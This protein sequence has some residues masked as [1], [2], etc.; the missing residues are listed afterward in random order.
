MKRGRRA[1]HV[2]DFDAGRYTPLVVSVGP[3]SASGIRT[4]GAP[5]DVRDPEKPEQP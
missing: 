1:A 2:V 4:R 3:A 5:E